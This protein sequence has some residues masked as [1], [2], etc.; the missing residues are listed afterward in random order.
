MEKRIETE[1][2]VSLVEVL[3][4]GSAFIPENTNTS[5]LLLNG[6]ILVDCGYNVFQK[7]MSDYKRQLAKELRYVFITHGHDDHIGSLQTL[8]YYNEFIRKSPLTIY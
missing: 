3:G 6:K 7:L 8:I 5:F 1:N 4:T 2:L